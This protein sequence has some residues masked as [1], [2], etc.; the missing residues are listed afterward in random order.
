MPLRYRSLQKSGTF[1]ITTSTYRHICYFQSPKQYDRLAQLIEYYKKRDNAIIHGYVLMPNHFHLLI[2]IP[3]NKSISDYMRD[4]KKRSVFE[5]KNIIPGIQTKLWQ[6]RFDDLALRSMRTY[7]TK[8][9]YIHNNPVKA[10]LVGEITQWPYSSARYY[11]G[12]QKSI[13][14]IKPIE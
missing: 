10:R 8:L 13:I 5:F 6:D 14:E 4:L 1:F 9:N 11:L 12:G 3:E 2:S 7:L